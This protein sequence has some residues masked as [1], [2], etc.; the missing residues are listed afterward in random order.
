MRRRETRNFAY[1]CRMPEIQNW[2]LCE[3]ISEKSEVCHRKENKLGPGQTHSPA[4]T[5]PNTHIHTHTQRHA[6]IH[7]RIHTYAWQAGSIDYSKHP[8]LGALINTG[9]IYLSVRHLCAVCQKYFFHRFLEPEFIKPRTGR[10]SVSQAH[11]PK[12]YWLSKKYSIFNMF[13][14]L[15]I[16]GEFLKWFVDKLIKRSVLCLMDCFQY[17]FMTPILLF[18]VLQV[19]IVIESWELI[20]EL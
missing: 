6:H 5:R 2:N 19:D 9:V 7:V 3:K 8:Q 13:W 18:K 1:E 11:W 20:Y 4:S 14:N 10:K 15:G 17:I 16:T 12:S